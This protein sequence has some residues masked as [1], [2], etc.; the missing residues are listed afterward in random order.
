MSSAPAGVFLPDGEGKPASGI[1]Q[2]L[3]HAAKGWIWAMRVR[4]FFSGLLLGLGCAAAFIG[5]LAL[6]LPAVTNDQLQLVLASFSAPSD[7]GFVQV[8]NQAMSVAFSN[9]LPLLIVGLLAA[10]AGGLLLL[11]FWKHA[12]EE[13]AP[14]VRIRHARPAQLPDREPNPFAAA[15]STFEPAEAPPERQSRYSAFPP[16]LEQNSIDPQPS[17]YARPAT[18]KPPEPPVPQYSMEPPRESSPNAVPIPEV[19]SESPS[20]SRL[21][22]RSTPPEPSPESSEKAPEPTPE[23]LPP[24]EPEKPFVSSRIRT[25]MGKHTL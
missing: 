8:V 14:S 2:T 7:N 25:T 4:R 3:Y 17:P 16:I 13:E 1:E 11:H 24:M 20:G 18:E 10:L 19:R 9:A 15:V 23:P 22:I 21:L 6:V 12:E 5:L